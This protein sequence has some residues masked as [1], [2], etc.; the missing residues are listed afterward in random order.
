M[1]AKRRLNMAA[2][3]IISAWAILHIRTGDVQVNDNGII[4]WKHFSRYWSSVRG[5]SRLP[6]DHIVGVSNILHDPWK[7]AD[8]TVEL[9]MIWDTAKLM[10]RHHNGAWAGFMWSIL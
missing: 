4:T 1:L 8:E 9:H 3:R 7:L 10:S 2:P 6:T 5:I